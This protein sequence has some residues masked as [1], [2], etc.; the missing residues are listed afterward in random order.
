MAVGGVHESSFDVISDMVYIL[1]TSTGTWSHLMN[2]PSTRTGPA[3]ISI[4]NKIIVIG[5]LTIADKKYLS[6][7]VWSGVFD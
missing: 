6:D 1:D 3:V 7:S 5:G 2:M 4:A